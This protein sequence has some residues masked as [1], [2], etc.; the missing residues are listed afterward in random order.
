MNRLK[1]CIITECYRKSLRQLRV[2]KQWQQR[3][4][5]HRGQN[6]HPLPTESRSISASPNVLM[7]RMTKSTRLGSFSSTLFRMASQDFRLA[8]PLDYFVEFSDERL[9]YRAKTSQNIIHSALL[10]IPFSCISYSSKLKEK[11][12]HGWILRYCTFL[13]GATLEKIMPFCARENGVTFEYNN[14]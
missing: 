9:Q 2:A 7:D 12:N 5:F 6:I 10:T 4:G 11:E 1:M 8:D 14:F 3:I 13:Q